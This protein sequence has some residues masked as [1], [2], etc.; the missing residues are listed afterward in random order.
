MTIKNDDLEF[1]IEL[2]DVLNKYDKI[3]N[4][5]KTYNNLIK[6][7]NLNERLIQERTK[8]RE[9]TRILIAEKRKINKEYGGH[10]RRSKKCIIK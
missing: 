10:K 8:R 5:D 7:I 1:L 3:Y 9:K 2:E 6:L 4:T